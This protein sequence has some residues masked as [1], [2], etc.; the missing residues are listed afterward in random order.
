[1]ENCVTEDIDERGGSLPFAQDVLQGELQLHVQAINRVGRP[2]NPPYR[3]AKA[4]SASSRINVFHNRFRAGLSSAEL[5]TI[6]PLHLPRQPR[7]TWNGFCF[8]V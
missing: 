6:D 8:S 4:E 3:R 5:S 7:Q 2:D 1:M